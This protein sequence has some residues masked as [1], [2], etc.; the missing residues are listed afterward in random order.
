M[1]DEKLV[2]EQ[3]SKSEP[4][5]SSYAN[6]SNV[7]DSGSSSSDGAGT[8][9]SSYTPEPASSQSPYSSL[10][11]SM[12]A[13]PPT[14]EELRRQQQ[15]LG[16]KKVTDSLKQQMESNKTYN[17]GK[18]EDLIEQYKSIGNLDEEA[19][20]AALLDMVKKG[21][22]DFVQQTL[23]ALDSTDRDDVSVALIT[24][25]PDD[26]LEQIVQEEPG[27]RLLDRLYD[28]LT[29]GHLG[30][31]EKEQSERIM[32]AK[33]QLVSPDEIG[34]DDL[35]VF[36]LMLPG[37]TKSA[38]IDRAERREGGK[39]YIRLTIDALG[40]SDY[41]SERKT[42]P[43]AVFVDGIELPE[44]EMIGVR[45][46]DE[47]KASPVVYKPAL[48]LVR[49]HNETNTRVAEKMTEAFGLGLTLGA[50][51]GVVLGAEATWG[52]RALLWADRIATVA[53]TLSS[54]IQENRGFIID[55]LGDDGRKFLEVND[56]IN[57]II[58]IYGITRGSVG[59]LKTLG[60]TLKS[61]SS[62]MVTL[63]EEGQLVERQLDKIRRIKDEAA[64]LAQRFEEAYKEAKQAGAKLVNEATEAADN[65]IQKAADALFPPQ[66]M[67]EH[68]YMPIPDSPAPK[69]GVLEK[70][71]M[72]GSSAKGTVGG[73]G[74]G[75]GKGTGKGSGKGSGGGSGKD[76][77]PLGYGSPGRPKMDPERFEESI[78]GA[79]KKD[80]GL[81]QIENV[82]G[83]TLPQMNTAP[84]QFNNSG[85][86]IDIFG[87]DPNTGKL[88]IIEV[89]VAET[90]ELKNVKYAG[91]DQ[92]TASWRS[93][94][95]KKFLAERKDAVST[96]RKLFG[97]A[98]DME[99]DIV[100]ARFL[101]EVE[102]C[103]YAFVVPE[104]SSVRPTRAKG[105]K[106]RDVYEYRYL[107]EDM[108]PLYE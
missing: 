74:K 102:D 68:G 83:R 53:G 106:A 45:M 35:K 94:A 34:R 27:R 55:E 13:G 98:D 97:W 11:S 64:I 85:N 49:L 23:D 54:L 89:S 56:R 81:G 2:S 1:G 14:A 104:G 41:Q 50:G 96:I 44:N 79:L 30:D 25:C 47:G 65:A 91:S 78:R 95:A 4:N 52:A 5:Y 37:F 46:Y 93:E 66:G 8:N 31:D 51:E 24:S 82:E 3:P 69:S 7:S 57:S 72:K 75:S 67:T 76:G 33:A 84:G 103:E 92:M 40:N 17:P 20:G 107:N 101:E 88:W 39:I 9:Y 29:D 59:V 18:P 61:L 32:T 38:T 86:G 43:T 80:G 21:K 73:S 48:F 90:K 63:A 58:A 62:K 6:Q 77:P 100:K 16:N 108:S 42:L 87:V 12:F 15:N 10:Q 71:G 36:P 99:D 70:R 26:L 22:F 105:F 28:E 19:L 60:G